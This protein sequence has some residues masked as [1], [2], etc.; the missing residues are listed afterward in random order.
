MKKT[1]LATT[2]EFDFELIGIVSMVKEYKLAWSL[3]QLKLFH[4]VKADDIK[5]EFTGHQQIL[6]S[7]LVYEDEY[8]VVH[9]LK[10]RLLSTQNG[11]NQYLIPDLSRFDY[12]LKVK[13]AVEDHWAERIYEQI[14]EAKI[15]DYVMK[16]ELD[17]IKQR[18]NLLF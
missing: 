5:I 15:A 10:N 14:R 16:I 4:L 8:A 9:L 7:N 18:E 11:S 12:L 2:Y 6:I 17:R 1:R 3:N 13:N